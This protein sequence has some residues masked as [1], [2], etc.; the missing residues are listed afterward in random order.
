MAASG[1][2]TP[3]WKACVA[4]VLAHGLYFYALSSAEAAL[5]AALQYLEPLITMLLVGWLLQ[6]PWTTAMLVGGG[7]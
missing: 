1:R 4:G 6:E 7:D 3:R 2:V 5:A